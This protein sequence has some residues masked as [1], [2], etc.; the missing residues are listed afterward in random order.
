MKRVL[1][2]QSISEKKVGGIGTRCGS[3]ITLCGKTGAGA[4]CAQKR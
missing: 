4:G 1:G 3:G 2:D